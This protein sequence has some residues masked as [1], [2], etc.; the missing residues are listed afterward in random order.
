M[1]GA[2]A[3]EMAASKIGISA[4]AELGAARQAGGSAENEARSSSSAI[5]RI[6][7]ISSKGEA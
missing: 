7:R 4:K 5:M 2:A 6:M 1:G 3:C